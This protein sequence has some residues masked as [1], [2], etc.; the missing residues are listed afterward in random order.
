MPMLLYLP[1]SLAAA[2]LDLRHRRIP[3]WLCLVT[4]V[5]GLFLAVFIAGAAVAGTHA[6]HTMISLLEGMVLFRIGAIGGGDAKFYSATSAWFPL[7]QAISLF[8]SVALCG[9]LLVIGWSI[10]RR[11]KGYPLKGNGAPFD[12]LPYGMAIGAGALGAMAA[13]PS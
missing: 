11:A 6:L 12:G 8:V 13:L 4:A 1:V 3:N 10:Y 9:L 2:W 5:S 7:S